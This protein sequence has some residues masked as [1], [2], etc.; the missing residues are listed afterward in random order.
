MATVYGASKEK[1]VLRGARSC[2]RESERPSRPGE[3]S[4]NAASGLGVW[5]AEAG[6]QA[7]AR[8]LQL[9]GATTA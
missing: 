1:R 2:A 8:E 9:T 4:S 6:V 5:G 7:Q 3:Y